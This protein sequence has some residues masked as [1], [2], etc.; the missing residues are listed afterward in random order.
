MNKAYERINWENYPSENTALNEA[1]LNKM[2]AALNEVDNRVVAHETT[3][4]DKATANSMVKNLSFNERT[5]IF[6]VTYLNGST[7]ELDTKLEK[8]ATNFV[9]DEERQKLI[10]TLIDGTTQEIDMSALITQYEFENSAYISFTVVNGKVKAEIINGSITADKLQPNFLADVTLQ[11]NSAKTSEQNAKV[12]EENAKQSEINA[13]NY[14][15]SA[16]PVASTANGLNPTLD[17]STGAPIISFKGDGAT[18]QQTYSGKNKFDIDKRLVGSINSDGDL[19]IPNTTA[20]FYEYDFKENTQYTFSAYVKNSTDTSNV[21]FR[22]Y[23]TDGTYADA[24]LFSQQTE[25]TYMEWTSDNGKTIDRIDMYYGSSGNMYIKGGKL[26]IEEGTEAT[27]YEPYVGGIASPNPDYPQEIYGVGESGSLS[28]KST[29]KNI[30]GGLPFAQALVDS[31]STNVVL[32]T[33][34]KTIKYGYNTTN[35]VCVL[36]DKFKE[37]TRH[38]LILGVKDHVN[39]GAAMTSYNL[40]LFIRY[41]DGTTDFLALT[42]T[43]TP[44]TAVI[45]TAPNKSVK[46]LRY[47]YGEGDTTTLYYEK[48]GIFEGV[49][50]ADEF[51]PYTETQADIP[52]SAPLYEGDYIRL[53]M[54]GT[55]EESHKIRSIVYDGSD[56]EWW[57]LF[58]NNCFIMRMF[59][60]NKDVAYTVISSHFT[61]MKTPTAWTA[62]QDGECQNVDYTIGFKK[63]GITT[64]AEWR[65]WLSENPI[66]VVY[67]KA[68]PTVTPLTA[69]Q[70]AEFEKLR[71]FDG[72]SHVTCEAE[73]EI[74]YFCD[75]VSGKAV[76]SV[77]SKVERELSDFDITLARTS[78]TA[79]SAFNKTKFD[80]SIL[81][82]FDYETGQVMSTDG[83]DLSVADALAHLEGAVIDIMNGVIAN[84]AKIDALTS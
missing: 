40:N 35:E 67:E 75:S 84:K 36:F 32:D 50:T 21:R 46:E 69:E 80:R 4:L 51:E 79:T 24:V 1:N 22:V 66:T 53:N 68:E 26:Q 38:T 55:G 59:A 30:F 65:T 77:V 17:N 28:V 83:D 71:T 76:A 9:Y 78:I 82:D 33:D 20:T 60:G 58:S 44:Y 48:C 52:L 10:L 8:I 42:K 70:I 14:A 49:I 11:A 34:A 74:Q 15:D 19:V 27:D 2:D 72:V 29:G 57:E 7:K 23:Y 31:G 39:A 6:T 5:G 47:Y 41:T 43:A 81:S 64:V 25:Y 3:K 73:S 13:K 61:G 16:E 54:D 37:N 18:E 12:S 63:N 45:T 56:D 62:L